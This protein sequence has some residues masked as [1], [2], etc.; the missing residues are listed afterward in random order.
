MLMY[1]VSLLI[2][3]KININLHEYDTNVIKETISDVCFLLYH[4]LCLVGANLRFDHFLYSFLLARDIFCTW[5]YVICM[6]KRVSR[7]CKCFFQDFYVEILRAKSIKSNFSAFI[8]LFLSRITENEYW[9]GLSTC[10]QDSVAL[11]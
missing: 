11:H 5:W 4:V 8:S 1:E 7:F 9:S 2:L 10:S 6:Y 3:P